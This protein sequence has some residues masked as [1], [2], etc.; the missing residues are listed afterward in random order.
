MARSEDLLAPPAPTGIKASSLIKGACHHKVTCVMIGSVCVSGLLVHRVC[1][2]TEKPIFPLITVSFILQRVSLF[3]SFFLYFFLFAFNMFTHSLPQYGNLLLTENTVFSLRCWSC[4]TGFLSF[5]I[6]QF[7]LRPVVVYKHI[8]H[9][10]SLY[11]T[12]LED[13]LILLAF[14][15]GKI[16]RVSLGP[17]NTPSWGK[18]YNGVWIRA[19]KWD[20]LIHMASAQKVRRD[21]GR[22]GQNNTPWLHSI[23]A[24]HRLDFCFLFFY[25]L[26]LQ[27]N[28]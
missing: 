14:S 20:A 28:L 22:K 25:F 27:N 1:A 18:I 26:L 19:L 5:F 23:R 13:Q 6:A 12:P 15:T 9:L 2:M 16:A 24:P 10:C 8:W 4:C 7:S 3:L 11:A 17:Y 21:H